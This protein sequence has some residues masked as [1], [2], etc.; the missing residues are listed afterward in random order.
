[1]SN[2][3][4]IGVDIGGTNIRAARI[5]ALGEVL[6]WATHPTANQPSLVSAQI[7][8]LV[9]SLDKGN[10]RAIGIGIPGRVDARLG[11]VLSGGYVDLASVSL[12][13]VLHQSF[14]QPL[15]I[16]NDC[17]MA[18]VAEHIAGRGRGVANVLMFTIGTGIGGAAII[19]GNVLRGRAAAGQLGHITVDVSGEQCLCGRRGCIETTSSGT[20]LG[21]HIAAAGFDARTSVE[22][23]VA[24]SSAG[25]AVAT[26]V[27]AAWARPMRA[28]I[29]TAV[30][31]FDPDLVILGG[32]LGN[33][34]HQALA[35][36]PAL[37][38]WYQCPVEPAALGDR[39]GVIGA[40]LSALTNLAPNP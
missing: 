13:S 3:T 10:V 4:A 27:L 31:A 26:S 12:A 29:D 18:L 16:D 33:A 39:A 9:R 35:N 15:F 22:D 28:A 5:S 11:R 34:M 7:A 1:M 20:A 21:R 6:E 25:D 32:G 24:R 30:A 17:N 14:Q 2:L 37:A 36:F 8:D 19:D 23:L 38:P 40:G